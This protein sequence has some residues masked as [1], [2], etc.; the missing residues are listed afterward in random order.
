MLK[1]VNG[2]HMF[3][4]SRLPTGDLQDLLLPVT[5]DSVE[6]CE[7]NLKSHT[8]PKKHTGLQSGV[9]TGKAQR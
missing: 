9:F 8:D 6:R 1:V 4:L 3:G 2:F 5:V 7:A